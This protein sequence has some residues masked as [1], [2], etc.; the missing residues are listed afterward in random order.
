M[1]NAQ[2]E[3]EL[4]KHDNFIHWRILKYRGR[5]D[6][7]DLYQEACIGFADA[8]RKYD[9]DSGN[10]ITT[11]A[12]RH[13]TGRVL[14]YLR[15]KSRTIR[16]PKEKQMDDDVAHVA[17]SLDALA[18]GDDVMGMESIPDAQTL[19]IQNALAK[20][21]P[22]YQEVIRLYYYEGYTP[23]EIGRMMGVSEAAAFNRCRRAAA[24]L[25]A[26]I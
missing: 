22:K 19:D 14:H 20:L 18:L 7:E 24:R 2:I 15:D 10:K 5:S 21:K 3:Q 12:G 25:K 26:Y 11:F 1:E 23:S 17:L 9:P 13:I 4:I 16:V 8:C 6:Y